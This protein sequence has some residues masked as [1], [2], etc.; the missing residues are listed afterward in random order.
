MGTKAP[1]LI[2]QRTAEGSGFTCSFCSGPCGSGGLIDEV[3]LAPPGSLRLMELSFPALLLYTGDSLSL[4]SNS[5]H[6]AT[7]LH[8]L[9]PYGSSCLETTWSEYCAL[10]VRCHGLGFRV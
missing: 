2:A 5:R 4:G 8:R 6:V 7:V 3:D 9:A 10:T 1:R